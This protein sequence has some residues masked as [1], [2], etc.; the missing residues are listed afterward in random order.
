MYGFK[1]KYSKGLRWWLGILR[2]IT[3]FSILVLLVNPKIKSETY[4]IEKPK[5][6]V[7]IDNSES[8]KVLGRDQEAIAAV[9][10]LKENT[11]LNNKFDL[12]FYNFGNEFRERDSLTFS[13]ANTNIAAALKSTHQ[14]F[15][16][17]VAPIV[18]ITDGNQTFGNDYE[19]STA[20][21]ENP[22]YPVILGDSTQFTDLKIERLN[23]NRYTFLKN[24]FPV[25]VILIYN[26]SGSV[27]SEF[28][29]TQGPSVLYRQNV[30]FSDSENSKTLQFTLP[31]TKIG[32]QRYTAQLVP[33]EI[34]KNMINNSKEFAVE[35]IDEATKVLI[36]S[37]I[38]HPDLGAMKKAISANE[39]RKV[40]LISPAEA[41]AVVNDYQL[42]ILYQPDRS[43]SSLYQEIEKHNKNTFTITGLQTDWS[44][45]N[46]IQSNFSKTKSSQI[47]YVT[48]INNPNYGS[49]AIDEVG[50]DQFR[51][52]KTFFGDLEIEVPYETILSQS[53]DG[54]STE[55]SLIATMEFNGTRS[56]IWDGE[57]FWKWRA[58][59]FLAS[60]NFL[61]FDNFMGKII[62]YLASS[63]SRSRLEVT[64][65][66]FYYKN[67]LIRI[68]AQYFDQNF[69]F[70]PRASLSIS[71]VN[72]E[73]QQQLILPMLLKNNFFE[74]DLNTL[75]SGEYDFE[76]AIN[77]EPI[78]RSGSFTILDY[79]VEQQFLNADVTKLQAVATHTNG[80]AFF[81]TDVESLVNNL[82]QDTRYKTIQKS[83][84]KSLPLID[85]KYLLALIVF[86]LSAEWFIRKY[87]GLI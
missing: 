16:N 54:F 34:E 31:A 73:S 75:A 6:P 56:A 58:E 17:E 63:K 15:K 81:I 43:F 9:S 50:F 25:E 84:L 65:E 29:I 60:E 30:T 87:N 40:Y 67:N 10:F 24:E 83:E 62:Q 80:K 48:A 46:D 61:D 33:L 77:G 76:I 85:W 36:V 14:L 82:I 64:S 44:F 1:E 47:D 70:N 11:E 41:A 57:G 38:A 26:G 35:V 20:M 18:I 22:I 37:K 12:L 21:L 3:I 7:L 71:V 68:T 19:F 2:F 28:K 8:I 72:S 53:I 23:S 59:A 49:F 74:I 78:R 39:Q 66:S 4:T 52:L 69:V 32:L 27:T 13:D 79:N 45:L 5:L 86:S 51:P 55:N 42:L